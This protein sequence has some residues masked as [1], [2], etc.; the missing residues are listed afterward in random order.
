LYSKSE[1]I[2]A[3][4]FERTPL[5]LVGEPVAVLTGVR[6]RGRW[7]PGMFT[8][9]AD[10]PLVFLQGGRIAERRTL[11]ILGADGKTTPLAIDKM[12][13]TGGLHASQD[14]A[15]IVFTATNARGL[16]ELWIFERTPPLARRLASYPDADCSSPVVSADGRWVAFRR[17]GR[18]QEDG[19]WLLSADGMEPPK[20][21]V[22]E[23]AAS[24]STVAPLGF[25][26]SGRELVLRRR[27]A[28]RFRHTLLSLDASGGVAEVERSIL[29]DVTVWDRPAFAPD[30]RSLTVTLDRQG[31]QQIHVADWDPQQG[32][33]R[34]RA[35]APPG[36]ILP[37]FTPDGRSI[38]CRDSTA[39]VRFAASGGEP[40]RA[41]ADLSAVEDRILNLYTLADG[42]VVLV[43]V[44]PEERRVQ[45]L[46]V[47]L[48]WPRE[49]A[50][51]LAP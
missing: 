17:D 16:D 4:R 24:D 6:T 49:L 27:E 18:G 5:R 28:G 14:G 11:A 43:L 1:T 40:A 37:R 34:F 21:I 9:A 35:V 15:R 51:A 20:R 46:D 31:V 8:A 32:A 19:V 41:I 44:E 39:I 42:S 38:V 25:T 10:G 3:Q 47:V 22:A 23:G 12:P 29:S 7:V 36:G 50:K 33:T 2:Y 30:G 13:F 48:D 26:P 45:H